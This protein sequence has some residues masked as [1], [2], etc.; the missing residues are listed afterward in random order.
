VFLLSVHDGAPDF[1]LIGLPTAAELPAIRWKQINIERL[2]TEN[3]KKHAAQRST[4]EAALRKGETD[5]HVSP[6]LSEIALKNP[7]VD[8]GQN[9]GKRGAAG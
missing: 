1:D 8:S 7:G 2:K 6:E 4:L 9:L 3:P 5:G